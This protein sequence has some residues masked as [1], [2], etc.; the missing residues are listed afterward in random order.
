MIA[1][2]A[3]LLALASPAAGEPMTAEAFEAL[4]EGRV[5]HFTRAGAPYGA[6]QYFPGRRSLWRYADGTCAEGVWWPEAGGVCFRY[7]AGAGAQCWRFEARPDG[8]AAELVED[9]AGTGFVLELSRRD[10][11]PLPCPGPKV[12]S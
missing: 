5:L 11:T 1:R 6:E 3:L 10:E 8:F 9:G 7:E 12:G 2:A 4:A